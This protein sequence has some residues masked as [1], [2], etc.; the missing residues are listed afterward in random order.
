MLLFLEYD[1]TI[2]YKP[3]K[4]HVVANALSGLSTITKPTCVHDQTVDASLFYTKL[5]WLNDLKEILRIRQ[6]ESMLSI[7][8]K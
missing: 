3:C 8:R 1:F 7:H 5:E 6:I 4:I 2:M